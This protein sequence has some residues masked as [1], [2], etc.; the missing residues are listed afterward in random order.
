[1]NVRLGKV[2]GIPIV[3]SQNWLVFVAIMGI[4]NLVT[5]GLMTA[6]NT[7]LVIGFVTGFIVLHE[8]GH[9]LTALQFGAKTNVIGLN[10][11]GGAAQ[12]SEAGWYKLIA[13]PFNAMLVWMAGPAV[14]VGLYFLLKGV[15]RILPGGYLSTGA[16][17]LAN[18]NLVLAIF[19]LMP[20]FP[21]DGGGILYCVLR[22]IFSKRIAIRITS[23]AGIIGSIIFILAAFKFRAIML[24]IIG[25]MALISSYNA[26]KHRFFIE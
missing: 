20:V 5:S 3:L 25:V 2:A 19:N 15:A 6:V 24:G 22:F 17:Y 8:L 16:M 18:T 23:V 12:I 21:L 9:S 4:L 11:F 13:K 7:L 14:S 26:P 10:F 1:M